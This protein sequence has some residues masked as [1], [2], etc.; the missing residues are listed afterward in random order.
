MWNKQY[1]PQQSRQA[2]QA[3]QNTFMPVFFV[4]QSAVI[5]NTLCCADIHK[6]CIATVHMI[7]RDGVVFVS[8]SNVAPIE[9]GVYLRDCALP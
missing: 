5:Y 9:S 2:R 3:R 1:K 8:V 7:F 6:Y 4:T